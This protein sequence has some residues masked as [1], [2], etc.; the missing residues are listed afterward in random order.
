MR[1]F[2]NNASNIPTYTR[3]L[4]DISEFGRPCCAC[5]EVRSSFFGRGKD[6]YHDGNYKLPSRH[7]IEAKASRAFKVEDVERTNTKMI[8]GPVVSGGG[9]GTL[10]CWCEFYDTDR[11]IN[12]HTSSLLSSNFLFAHH[13]A[14]LL[15]H[16]HA[17]CHWL[18][19]ICFMPRTRRRRA[20]RIR[21]VDAR[22]LLVNE[23]LRCF[24]SACQQVSIQHRP[25]QPIETS[26]NSGQ[27]GISLELDV[28]RHAKS[29]RKVKG[30][31]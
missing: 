27:E 3:H 23:C 15:I 31:A 26:I 11:E 17:S 24:S 16:A 8:T 2:P 14:R 1:N 21:G 25:R 10:E 7:K 28:R 19:S 30:K 20:V 5:T 9:T 12:E 13:S 4:G 22:I 6:V 18:L 29:R